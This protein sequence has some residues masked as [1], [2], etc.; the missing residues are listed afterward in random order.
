MPV[1]H[2]P[3]E[4]ALASPQKHVPH[5]SAQ[6]PVRYEP[7]WDGWRGVLI[8][9]DNVLQ[10]R[11]GNNL[12][13]RFPELMKAA[14]AL[15]DVALDG[16]IVALRA[17]RLDFGALTSSPRGRAA[18]GITIYFVAFDLLAE[19]ERDLRTANC[20][21]RR[22]RLEE[23]MAGARPPLQ[24]TPITTDRDEAVEWMHPAV[25]A[26]GIE[27]CVVKRLDQPYR[28]GRGSD[29][30]K[31]RHTVVVDAIVIGATGSP[32]APTELLLARPDADGELRRIGLSHPLS[33]ALRGQAW[34]H[35]TLTGE[36]PVRLSTGAFASR[37]ETEYKPVQP[38]LVVEVEAEGSVHSF[39]SRLRPTVHQLR[40]DLT[41]SDLRPGS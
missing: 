7:K 33:S 40:P 41:P 37:T 18:A 38:T 36:P 17:G 31:I 1:L 12:A 35:L 8:T 30:I 24:L 21:D 4:V 6:R 10:S 20:Q 3:V 29:W 39:T 34:R 28:A 32:T 16:E 23:V 27:G 9:G 2:A 14:G 15:G 13:G 11:R 5:G 25:A 26:V 22:A 19:G